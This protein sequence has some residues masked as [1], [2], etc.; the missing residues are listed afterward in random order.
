MHSQKKVAIVFYGLTRNLVNTIDSIKRN[1]F[2]VLNENNITF[3]IFIHT[4]KIYG[5]YN[6]MWRNEKATLYKNEDVTMLLSPKYSISD[7]QCDIENSINFNDYYSNLGNWTGMSSELTKN[8]IK[9][10]VI[11]LYS[12]KQITNILK[13]CIESYD[14]VI[15]IRPELKLISRVD[16]QIFNKLSDSNIFIPEKD[17]FYGCNDRF[18]IAKSSVALYY[19]SLYEYLLEYS[20]KNSII[21]ERFLLHMLKY[22]NIEINTFNLE[23]ETTSITYSEI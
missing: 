17:W 16:V 9:T 20:K 19:G 13:T 10:M 2:D 15:F 6:S 18:C 22:K 4:Y 11:A 23:Y 7:I 12:K 5:Q 3:D 21:S 8:L 14:Y 1:L